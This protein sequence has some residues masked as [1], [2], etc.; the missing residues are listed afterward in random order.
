MAISGQVLNGTKATGE[1]GDAVQAPC[2]LAGANS[3]F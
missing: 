1:F 2:F 3:I